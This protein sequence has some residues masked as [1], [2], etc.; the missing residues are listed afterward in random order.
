MSG[1][2]KGNG[3]FLCSHLEQKGMRP[4]ERD[5][6][7]YSIISL[8]VIPHIYIEELLLQLFR[9]FSA[10]VLT[11]ILLSSVASACPRYISLVDSGA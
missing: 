4:L 1:A 6:Y 7:C 5:R 3:R 10:T 9:L 2:D 8:N 11:L